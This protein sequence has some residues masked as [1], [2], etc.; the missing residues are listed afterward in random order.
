MQKTGLIAAGTAGSSILVKEQSVASRVEN[1]AHNTMSRCEA[2]AGE[3]L[4]KMHPILG[5]KDR[6]KAGAES[7]RDTYPP[8]F[9]SLEQCLERID[10]ALDRIETVI[11][12]TEL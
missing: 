2:L 4:E 7:I 6:G 8:L 1:H 5:L 3:L 11:T 12:D 10:L 9:E